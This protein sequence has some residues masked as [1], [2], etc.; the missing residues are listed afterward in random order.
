M[1]KFQAAYLNLQIS[2]ITLRS[3]HRCR[4]SEVATVLPV[5]SSMMVQSAC[6]CWVFNEKYGDVDAP[7]R[8][9]LHVAMIA[10]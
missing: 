1:A 9:S 2:E 7:L 6:I 5:E 3:Y 8:R 4:S 10:I